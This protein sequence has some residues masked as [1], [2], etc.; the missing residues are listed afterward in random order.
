MIKII[1]KFR[2]LIIK[3]NF[4]EKLLETV[5]NFKPFLYYFQLF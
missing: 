5:Y 1:F 2:K 3:I 4:F